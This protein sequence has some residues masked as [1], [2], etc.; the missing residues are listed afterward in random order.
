MHV[1]E[2]V[3]D[4][5]KFAVVGDV[6]IDLELALQ[7]VWIVDYVVEGMIESTED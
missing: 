7:V 5:R 4:F 3:V 6:F 1:V 2:T